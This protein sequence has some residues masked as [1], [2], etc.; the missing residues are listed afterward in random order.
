MHIETELEKSTG[1]FGALIGAWGAEKATEP[2]LADSRTQLT[3]REVAQLTARIAAQ[4]QRDDLQPGQ[5]VA[6]LGASNI[7]YALVYLAAIRAGGCAA[8]LTT[9][10]APA[11]LAAM[12]KD[13]GAMHLFVDAAKLADLE[14]VALGDVKIIMIGNAVG[15]HP[16][17]TDWM[18]QE[19]AAFAAVTP[20]ATDPFNI[21]YSSGT[22]V[23]PNGIIHSHGMRWRR[24]KRWL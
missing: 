5:A 21:I 10:A 13:S 14:G 3:W 11:Q 16:A 15:D 2:A 19:G 22:T 12:L 23:T 4:L 6:I 18:A 1:D 8:P 17:L 7:Q 9:S 20:A 24:H